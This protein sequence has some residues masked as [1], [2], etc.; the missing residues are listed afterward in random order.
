MIPPASKPILSPDTVKTNSRSKL[1]PFR[2]L[3]QDGYW[4][5]ASLELEFRVFTL[6]NVKLSG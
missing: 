5:C 1:K 4:I 6:L 2:Q 3:F